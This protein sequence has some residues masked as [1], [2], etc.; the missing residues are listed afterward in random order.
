[1]ASHRVTRN[2]LNVLTLFR[3]YI[4]T[5]SDKELLEKCQECVRVIRAAKETQAARANQNATILLEELDAE[6]CR[7]ETRRQAAARRRERK[8]KKKMEKKVSVVRYNEMMN[9][10]AGRVRPSF[11][12]STCAYTCILMMILMS[13]SLRSNGP[14]PTQQRNEC[15][16]RE[17][18][19]V[20][21]RCRPVTTPLPGRANIIF[22]FNLPCVS[23]GMVT[24]TI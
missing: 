6:R 21:L 2:V 15:F 12:I 19:C 24:N 14:A 5:I 16:F 20:T 23:V 17:R 3:R 11:D 18:L 9:E 10:W 8:K 4:C 13:V 1:M 7:E 22:F